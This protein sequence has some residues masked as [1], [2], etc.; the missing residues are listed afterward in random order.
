MTA[1]NPAWTPDQLD[2]KERAEAGECVV[3]NL[4]T[5]SKGRRKDE[6]LLTWAEATGRFVYIGRAVP[7]LKLRASPFHNPFR[8]HV[9]GDRESV[10]RKFAEYWPSK[11]ELH[12]K[13]RTLRGKVLACW[14]HPEPCHGHFIAEWVNAESKL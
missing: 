1:L 8:G 3:A 2:R 4:S 14:C 13:A 7:R 5:V 6:A 12:E 10:C 9:H 11:P